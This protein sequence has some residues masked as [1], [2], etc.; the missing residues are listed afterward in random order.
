M[1]RNR[2]PYVPGSCQPISMRSAFC[3][4]R[5]SRGGSLPSLTNAA[6]AGASLTSTG[7]G[8]G[9]WVGIGVEVAGSALVAVGNGVSVGVSEG[10]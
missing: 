3:G 2:P 7:V 4:R 9:V 1:E 5:S 8:T 6:S 10:H